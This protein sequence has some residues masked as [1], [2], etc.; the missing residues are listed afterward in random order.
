MGQLTNTSRVDGGPDP[1]GTIKEVVRIKIRHYRNGF[2]SGFCITS[3]RREAKSKTS[4][5]ESVSAQ[6]VPI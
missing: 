4:L 6:S 5:I 1:D 2:C 3:S